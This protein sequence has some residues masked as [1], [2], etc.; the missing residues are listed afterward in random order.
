[1]IN[2]ELVEYIDVQQ[3]YFEMDS[4]DIGRFVSVFDDEK[5]LKVSMNKVVS[6]PDA[7]TK[8]RR[9]IQKHNT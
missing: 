2:V 5:G 8:A 1:M 6:K 3:Y 9:T 4:F 7:I